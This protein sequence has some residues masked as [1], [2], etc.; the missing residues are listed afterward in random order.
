MKTKKM[1]AALLALMILGL[2]VLAG[3]TPEEPN[4][5]NPTVTSIA[6]TTAPT[7]TE[8]VAGENFDKTG[9]V[10]TVTYSD[11]TTAEVT[12]YTVDKTTLSGEDTEVTVFYEG[13]TA[14]QAITVTVP[15]EL[16][17]TFACEQEGGEGLNL[18]ND[19]TLVISEST[20]Y[21]TTLGW[22]LGD[23][24]VIEVAVPDAYMGMLTVTSY[25]ANGKAIINVDSAMG[26]STLYTYSL[27]EYKKLFNLEPAVVA[28][29]EN[30]GDV[31][32]LF[33]IGTFEMTVGGVTTTGEAVYTEKTNDAKASFVLK[34][35]SGDEIAATTGEYD[36]N[37]NIQDKFVIADGKLRHVLGYSVA[38][39]E[40]EDMGLY[41]YAD[42]SLALVFETANGIAEYPCTYVFNNADLANLTLDVT[43][44]VPSMYGGPALNCVY[45]SDD[46]EFTFTAVLGGVTY[47]LKLNGTEVN[48]D[49]GAYVAAPVLYTINATSATRPT[50]EETDASAF[51]FVIL[52]GGAC[53][54]TMVNSFTSTEMELGT[55][56][57]QYSADAGFG[58]SLSGS[59][60]ANGFTF[61]GL[62]A[63]NLTITF[64]TSG[65]QSVGTVVFTLT[66]DQ[67]TEMAGALS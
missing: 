62:A 65:M 24:G 23:D 46:D 13:K 18:Y 26:G 34:P 14:K 8:Y 41:L 15:K 43:C 27:S 33:D 55:G 42:G 58:F 38:G 40:T 29:I 60:V 51:S 36:S 28:T 32:K 45:S 52:Q 49:L 57:W 37:F 25:H 3:C 17:I 59:Y 1:L 20:E 47:E 19:G 56:A 39:Y 67:W 44:P 64:N 6:I 61:G 12:D 10:V 4:S 22:E 9:M 35:E 31:L 2:A 54:I 5:T 11:G 63:D 16:V 21:A 30:G 66:A 50:G 7:K 53:K 48:D